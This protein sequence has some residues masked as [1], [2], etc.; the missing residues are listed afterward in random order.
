MNNDVPGVTL[1]DNLLE[2]IPTELIVR[3]PELQAAA[4]S[5][6]ALNFPTYMQPNRREGRDRGFTHDREI[7]CGV[8]GVQRRAGPDQYNTSGVGTRMHMLKRAG[9]H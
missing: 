6:H 3:L 2:K 5:K 4:P 1:Q 8:F 9:A 7:P